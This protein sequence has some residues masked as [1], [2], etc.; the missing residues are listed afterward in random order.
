MTDRE[1]AIVMAYTGT[2]MLVGEKL[3]VFYKYLEELFGRPVYTHELGSDLISNLIKEKSKDDFMKLCSEE[4]ESRKV[5]VVQRVEDY[6]EFDCPQ[7]GKVMGVFTTKE[8]AK[9]FMD[10]NT[11]DTYHMFIFEYNSIEIR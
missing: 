9:K 11:Y 5:Y 3:E 6:D 7:L 2:C 8:G 10:K 4:E 1:K